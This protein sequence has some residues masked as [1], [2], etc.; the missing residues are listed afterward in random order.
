MPEDIGP[1][2][3]MNTFRGIVLL[4]AAGLVGYPVVLGV[5]H[6]GIAS[7]V[8][9]PPLFD[10]LSAITAILLATGIYLMISPQRAG[11]N[12]RFRPDGLTLHLGY[13]IFPDQEH[14]LSWSD[15]EQVQVIKAA[16]NNQGFNIRLNDGHVVSFQTRYFSCTTTEILAR[17]R[18]S[19]EAAG[20]HLDR[21][22]AFNVLIFS[23]QTWSVLP[24]S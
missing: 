23:R 14:C 6:E 21:K 10:W 12:I 18:T 13:Y 9:W 3:R 5:Y 20:Y 1:A 22:T 17:L 19:A 2:K 7:V 8:D 4:A 16:Y 24:M 11:G 15:I